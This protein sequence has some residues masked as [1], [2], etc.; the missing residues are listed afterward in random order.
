MDDVLEALPVELGWGLV[1]ALLVR[2]FIT[3]IPRIVDSVSRAMTERALAARLKEQVRLT[4][5][6]TMREDG[7]ERR[8]LAQR[9]D[10]MEKKLREQEETCAAEID[11]AHK[12]HQR[13]AD[14][15]TRIEAQHVKCERALK[16]Q[17]AEMDQL[18]ASISSM[19]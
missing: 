8:S 13:T 1:V 2:G 7:Q 10:A 16:D 14:R 15:L 6:E 18:R 3:A 19:R 17:A 11:S 4:E 9:L 12:M 5:A